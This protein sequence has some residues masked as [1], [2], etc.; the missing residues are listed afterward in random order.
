MDM[1]RG[2]R[3]PE[4]TGSFLTIPAVLSGQVG[5]QEASADEVLRECLRSIRQ[6]L[7]M[8][9]AFIAE[10]ADGRRRF[11]HVDSG[12]DPAP[13]SP[14]HSDPLEE[15]YCQ[16]VVDGRLP[17]LI[18]DA[19][20]HPV[21]RELPVTASLPVGAHLSVPIRLT[22]GS[23]FGTFC[24]FSCAPD[25]TLTDR[26]L[27]MLRVFADFAGLQLDRQIASQRSRKEMAT[28]VRLA[29]EPGGLR[30]FL[31]PIVDFV[32][33][34]SVG[35]E[36]LSRFAPTPPRSPDVWFR[37][38]AEVGL[39]EALELQAIRAALAELPRLPP[40]TY[41]SLNV[42]PEQL[43]SGAIERALGDAPLS[44]IVLEVTEHALVADYAR[45]RALVDPL[46]ARGLRLAIDDAGAGFASFRHILQLDPN[47]IKLDMSLI[48]HIDTD[49]RRLALAAALIRFAEQTS[50][51]VIAEGVETAEELE[52]LR[53]LGVTRAQGYLLGRPAPASEAIAR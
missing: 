24:C 5:A 17:Q 28:R 3:S 29:L 45:L 30:C 40:E 14:G 12:L 49:H 10:F 11:V 43:G 4:Q 20:A 52:A 7:D 50:A 39:G 32:T 19:A 22:D 9:V 6:H 47:L 37:E 15:S 44:R 46:R 53:R 41:L 36:A 16:R 48:R 13:V 23:V 21:A 34:R 51:Q 26:D 33:G 27:A 25:Q 42:S 8:D 18:H 38:A 1:P 2:R 35:Y 31:Q